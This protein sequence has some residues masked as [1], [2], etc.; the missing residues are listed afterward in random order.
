M[1]GPTGAAFDSATIR[2]IS[3]TSIPVSSWRR[4]SSDTLE[5]RIRLTTNPGASP[6][7]IGV[8]RIAWAKLTAPCTVSGEV[9]SPSI[10]SIS[11]IT[12]AG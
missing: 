6:Q 12:D 1:N 4:H 8:L 3:L 10:T 2:S 5:F 9:S 11:R 7:R